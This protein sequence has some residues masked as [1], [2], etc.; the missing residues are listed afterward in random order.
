MARRGTPT[1][2]MGGS[3]TRRSHAGGKHIEV[4]QDRINIRGE[5][6]EAGDV[7]KAHACC[8]QNSGKIVHR[9]SDLASHVPGVLRGAVSVD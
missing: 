6:G 7:R 3:G 1:K 5:H 2:V 9:E 4:L 8:G